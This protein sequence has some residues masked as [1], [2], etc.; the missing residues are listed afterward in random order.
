[1]KLSALVLL[2]VVVLMPGGS[3]GRRLRGIGKGI[4]AQGEFNLTFST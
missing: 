4:S 1:M 2:A 3:K